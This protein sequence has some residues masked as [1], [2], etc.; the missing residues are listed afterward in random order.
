MRIQCVMD[1]S[2]S[3]LLP[4]SLSIPFK[5]YQHVYKADDTW[6]FCYM[7][8]CG[9]L[10]YV[11]KTRE[12]FRHEG[13]ERSCSALSPAII[14]VCH[15]LDSLCF[16]YLLSISLCREYQLVLLYVRWL[17]ELLWFLILGIVW[18]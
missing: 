8:L 1:R 18:N 11:T 4:H 14:T 5:L 17:Q 10:F 3:N 13:E 16:R 2:P 7:S 9:H 12:E 15:G 6:A